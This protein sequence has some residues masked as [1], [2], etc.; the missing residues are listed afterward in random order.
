[1]NDEVACFSQKISCRC[2]LKTALV[3]CRHWFT[4]SCYQYKILRCI[5][6]TA[7]VCLCVQLLANMGGR[8]SRALIILLNHA[9]I[10]LI[11]QAANFACH[12]S[13]PFKQVY[14]HQF[15]FCNYFVSNL[16]LRVSTKDKRKHND[17]VDKHSSEQ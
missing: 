17:P 4:C 7:V 1:M 2:Q 11:M 12:L 8:N 6:K 14:Q 16:K 15:A 10:M 5:V 9:V 3:L 13:T